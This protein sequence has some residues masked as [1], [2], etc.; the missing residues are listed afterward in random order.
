MSEIRRAYAWLAEEPRHLVGVR[1]LQTA[2]GVMLLI[3]VFTEGPFRAHLWGP[4][5]LAGPPAADPRGPFEALI[6]LA[7]A[8]GS[9]TL[10]V[11]VVLGTGALALVLGVRTR[12]AT[13]AALVTFSMIEFRLP[14]LGDGGDNV[15][16]L[17]LLYM[18]FL[19]PAGARPARG[20][21]AVWIH[22]VAVLALALQL[23]VLYATSGWMKAFGERWH[24]GT[25]MYYISQ[26]EWFSL[27]SLRP[28]F[29]DP[30][31]TTVSTYLPMAYQVL[32]GVAIL[33]PLKLPWLLLG[34]GF[35]VGVAVF[36]GLV[37][38]STAMIG[39]ELMLISDPEYARLGGWLRALPR[40][41]ARPRAGASGPRL[42]V[43]IDGFCPVCVSAGE[44]LRRVDRNDALEIVSF[45]HGDLHLEHGIPLAA[46]EERMH[47]VDLCS[48]KVV[49][50]FSAM[51][52]LAGVLPPLRPL[53]PLLALAAAAGL[54]ERAYRALARRRTIVPDPRACRDGC[55]I[56]S[57]LPSSAESA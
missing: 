48:G 2:I 7:F 51:R 22:N 9:G 24:A 39:M 41:I 32:F 46:L 28:L 36:M 26:V 10:A 37:T 55:E 21:L 6:S 50:G 42:R 29:H 47:V 35:H 13:A 4:H 3:R 8:S 20:G 25:A 16:R 11:L 43:F 17:A 34:V 49:A 12:A 5:G 19:L 18:L 40:R 56:P 53:R 15:V 54:G 38:F 27:P 14:E 30:L 52:S 23:V 33:S 44:R 1:V 45:R 31:V 57:S